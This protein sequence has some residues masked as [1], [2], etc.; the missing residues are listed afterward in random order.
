MPSLLLADQV[1]VPAPPAPLSE[2]SLKTLTQLPSVN[3]L[4]A[5]ISQN[6]SSIPPDGTDPILSDYDEGNKNLLLERCRNRVLKDLDNTKFFSEN[7]A[8]LDVG[9]LSSSKLPEDIELVTRAL[10]QDNDYGRS[11]A[12]RTLFAMGAKKEAIAGLKRLALDVRS[13][14]IG[15]QVGA[16]S[17]LI[18]LG[19][20][21][22]L[23]ILADYAA[24]KVQH[25]EVA[26]ADLNRFTGLQ[27][28]EASGWQDWWQGVA[29][30]RQV[31]DKLIL[32]ADWESLRK[33]L[34]TRPWYIELNKK[35][36]FEKR[37]FSKDSGAP[38]QGVFEE[39]IN[40][41]LDASLR[42]ACLRWYA[43][44]MIPV[45]ENG[46][47]VQLRAIMRLW[48]EGTSICLDEF[49]K[50][51]NMAT[52]K[53]REK[54]RDGAKSGDE[55]SRAWNVRY[56]MIFGDKANIELAKDLINSENPFVA[57]SAADAL[58]HAGKEKAAL[59]I[60]Q[61]LANQREHPFYSNLAA[62]R[63][64]AINNGSFKPFNVNRCR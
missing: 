24:M 60:L 5:K 59:P 39:S 31:S 15:Y 8:I 20:L 52:A 62:G 12:I 19:E 10:K 4:L 11:E 29:A 55:V 25:S 35:P 1:I 47:S 64:S 18:E 36:D 32:S 50:T 46:Q 41:F 61:K 33:D 3:Y 53:N 48:D 34:R 42:T 26:M 16:A 49:P 54:L 28:S 57:W 43:L 44:E 27:F 38:G 56:L 7:G 6:A 14:Y 45:D 9:C 51:F 63:I 2:K 21:E 17:Q 30:G 22:W 13:T 58:C 40:A 23:G 37:F